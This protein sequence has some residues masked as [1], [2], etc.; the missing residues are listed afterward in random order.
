MLKETAVKKKEALWCW[1]VPLFLLVGLCG[2]WCLLSAGGSLWVNWLWPV[3]LAF[4]LLTMVGGM[5]RFRPGW[6]KWA[7][8]V[9]LLLLGIFLFLFWD[10]LA[11][12]WTPL[13]NHLLQKNPPLVE[14]TA[15]LSFLTAA[16]LWVMVFCLW[17]KQTWLV[18]LGVTAL[19]LVPT[20]FGGSL[21]WPA[22]LCL[23]VF[24]AAFA[25]LVYGQRQ[26]SHGHR[27]VLQ[28]REGGLSL[29]QSSLSGVA[30]A[31]SL[32]LVS[33][34]LVHWFGAP[35]Y[36][37]A[38]RV[39]YQVT[40][41]QQ[42]VLPIA[43]PS[44][45]SSGLINRGSMIHSDEEQIAAYTDRLPTETLYLKGF[46]GGDYL[47]G[48]WEEAEETDLF[49]QLEQQMG[50][51]WENRAATAF[52]YLYYNLNQWTNRQTSLTPRSLTL[53]GSYGRDNSWYPPYYYSWSNSNR[54]PDGCSFTYYQSSEVDIQWERLDSSH[55]YSPSDYQR[56]QSGYQDLARSAYTQV[57]EELVPQLVALC[58]ENPQDN[59]EET[60]RFVR[61]V[62]QDRIRYTTSPE[63]IP[64]Q[65]DPVEYVLFESHEGYCQHFASA[66][67]LMFR[68]YG[69][70][71][72]YVS[73]YLVEPGAFQR[74]AYQQY[75]AVITGGNAHA[76]AEIFLEDRGWVPVEVTFSGGWTDDFVEELSPQLSQPLS[77][78]SSSSSQTESQ[79]TSSALSPQEDVETPEGNGF[80]LPGWFWWMFGG[81]LG[82][83]ALVLLALIWRVFRLSRFRLRN[84]ER[85]SSFW[86]KFFRK[87]E[88][89]RLIR[90]LRSR[91]LGP[92]PPRDGLRRQWGELVWVLRF[93]GFLKQTNLPPEELMSRRP[94]TNPFL[95]PQ[96]T[97]ELLDLFR[98]A[99]YGKTPLTPAQ[100]RQVRRD[101]LQTARG[102][103][104]SLPW[105]RKLWFKWV[106]VAL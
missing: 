7:L 77:E 4:G 44:V 62:L 60:I 76:W 27:V 57:P 84:L 70:P 98:Q 13:L 97:R 67:V 99:A 81:I 104:R 63:S 1:L 78:T 95:S 65:A 45:V 82:A 20:L 47:G 2:V 58:R 88:Q 89:N 74:Q 68:L 9:W 11:P 55:G 66:A 24:Q 31:L 103:Y 80:S 52:Q 93:G 42:M 17:A 59:L 102:V 33:L 36:R 43:S 85:K 21:S 56:L 101:Y 5:L 38:G 15:L 37:L 34:L 64:Y 94:E 40:Q 14:V 19:L 79:L 48:S 32:L 23:A 28:G 87:R 61:S 71:A 86:E 46:T 3:A 12:Q 18:W 54:L 51:G 49:Q 69:I 92:P 105:Y 25:A 50:D 90:A 106:R 6:L 72:R 29:K 73:G 16:L 10:T 91:G 22:F 83:M 41:L 8:L 35:L 75:C 100:M 26:V 53:K 96:E 39:Q 30:L